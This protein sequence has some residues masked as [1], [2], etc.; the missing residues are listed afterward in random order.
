MGFYE[1]LKFFIKK[2]ATNSTEFLSTKTIKNSSRTISIQ[3]KHYFRAQELTSS[4]STIDMIAKRIIKKD[5]ANRYYAGKR[6]TDIMEVNERIYKYESFRTQNVNL[7]PTTDGEFDLYIENINLGRLPE[8][9]SQDVRFYL[10]TTI[11][12]A[13]TYIKGGAYKYFDP[14]TQRIVENEDPYDLSIYIQFS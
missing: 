1:K 5:S 11:F 14:V 10:Q 2:H 7:V 8:N 9:F 6:D 4:Q 13:F 3:F 12:M